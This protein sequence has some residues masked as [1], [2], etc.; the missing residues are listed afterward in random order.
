MIQ[1]LDYFYDAQQERFLMQIVRAFSGFQ[2]M[3]GWRD[4]IPPHLVMVP[5]RMASRDKLVAAIV[6]NASVNTI[7]TVP[8]ITIAQTGL[9]GRRGDL[10]N[11]SHVDTRQVK[12][13]RIDDNGAYA[14]DRGRSRCSCRS[15]SGPPTIT[16]SDN[17]PSRS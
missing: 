16:R 8:M 14:S 11:P 2:Y 15:T 10:Q 4:D 12:E 1:G 13:R 6:Q 3:T 17:W 5:C 7:L 9:A